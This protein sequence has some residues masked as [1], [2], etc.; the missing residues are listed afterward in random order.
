DPPQMAVEL[1]VNGS[2]RPA[3]VDINR[4]GRA[5]CSVS[6]FVRGMP[7][8]GT[9]ALSVSGLPEGVTAKISP[10]KIDT[11]HP[12]ATILLAAT[13]EAMRGSFTVTI[14]GADG[15]LNPTTPFTLKVQ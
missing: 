13:S 7:Y 6:L 3:S 12:S 8:H 15:S 10:A 4:G 14:A 1:R 5:S 9:L 2:L 11:S